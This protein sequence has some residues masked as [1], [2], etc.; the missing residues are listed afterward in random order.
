MIHLLEIPIYGGIV[1]LT[2]KHDEFVEMCND[3][4]IEFEESLESYRGITQEARNDDG[5]VEYIV[6]IFSDGQQT[7][8]HELLHVT[9][10][11]ISDRGFSAHDGHG[12]PACYL[13]DYMWM[14]FGKIFG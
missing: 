9:L 6:G 1:K 10:M 14:K 11:I 5:T 7:L 4:G 13:M 2:D 8:V 12:E 3:A